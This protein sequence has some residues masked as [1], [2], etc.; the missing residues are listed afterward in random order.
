MAASAWLIGFSLEIA[1]HVVMA[2]VGGDQCGELLFRMRRRLM[3]MKVNELIGG[4][5]TTRLLACLRR[6]VPILGVPVHPRW[7]VGVV[8]VYCPLLMCF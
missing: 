7:G 4:S 5:P 8:G 1:G 3:R 2:M 6:V